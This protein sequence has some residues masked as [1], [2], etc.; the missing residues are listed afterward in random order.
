LGPNLTRAKVGCSP[1]G[2]LMVFKV[3]GVRDT[4][5]A[6]L[7]K[8]TCSPFNYLRNC[9]CLTLGNHPCRYPR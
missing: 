3:T 1:D 5:V 2:G 6:H 8:T 4:G 9:Q 7:C